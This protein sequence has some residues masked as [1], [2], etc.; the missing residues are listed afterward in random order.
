MQVKTHLKAG[1][2][3]IVGNVT[4]EQTNTSEVHVTQSNTSSIG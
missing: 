1:Q 2:L 4:V 3:T